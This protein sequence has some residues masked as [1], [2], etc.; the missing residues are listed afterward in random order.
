MDW[1]Y[2]AAPPDRLSLNTRKLRKSRQDALTV[3]EDFPERLRNFPNTSRTTP[4]A[5]SLFS[6]R[7]PNKPRS[8]FAIS[9]TLPEQRRSGFAI[10][11]ILPEAGPKLSRSLLVPVDN[12][13]GSGPQAF[14]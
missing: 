11:R 5:A 10:S 12:L 13:F 1:F 3:S 2:S 6:E 8:S 9:R 4:E 14:R 7:F